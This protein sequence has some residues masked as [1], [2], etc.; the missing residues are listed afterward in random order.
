MQASASPVSACTGHAETAHMQEA[1][2]LQNLALAE[3]RSWDVG[4]FAER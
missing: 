2:N 3:T 4:K 1:Q